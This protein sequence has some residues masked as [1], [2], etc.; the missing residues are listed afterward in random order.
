MAKTITNKEPADKPTI[1]PTGN[2]SWLS[3]DFIKQELTF[4]RQ[5]M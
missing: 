2:D 4:L 3:A 1:P 5:L